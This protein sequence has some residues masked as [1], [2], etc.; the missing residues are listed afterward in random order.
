MCESFFYFNT[1]AESVFEVLLLLLTENCLCIVMLLLAPTLNDGYR[2]FK[3]QRYANNGEA[4]NRVT[5]P[6]P[7]DHELPYVSMSPPRASDSARSSWP[8][9]L[10]YA[11]SSSS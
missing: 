10:L 6:A 3:I 9:Q 1:C 5:S 7:A 11:C 2:L 8:S 4:D